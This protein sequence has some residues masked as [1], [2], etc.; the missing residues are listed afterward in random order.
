MD[1]QISKDSEKIIELED[2]T[3]KNIQENKGK[4]LDDDILINTLEKT[5]RI[6]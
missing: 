2:M 1:L 4:I 5:N 6:Q 3:L